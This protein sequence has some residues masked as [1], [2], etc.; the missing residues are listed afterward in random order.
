MTMPRRRFP[1]ILAVAL[2]LAFAV[3]ISAHAQEPDPLI[4]KAQAFL[5]ALTS[6]DFQGAAK[7][8]DAKMLELSGPDKL[9]AFWTQVPAQIGAFKKFTGAVRRE[10]LGTYDIVLVTM[11]FGKNVLDAR[12]VFDPDGKI[13]GFQFL[14]S[15]PPVSYDPPAYA[16][17]AKFEETEVTVGSGEWAL[18][19]TLA[20]PK[21]PGPFPGLVLVHGSGPNDRDE[22]VG[23]NKPFKDLAWGLATRGIAVL[24]YEKR[25]RMHGPLMV[26]NP[27]LAK[28]LTVKEETVDDAALAVALLRSTPRVDPKRVFVLGHSLGGFLMPRIAAAVKPPAAGYIVMAGLARPIPETMVR[29]VTYLSGLDGSISPEEQKEIDKLKVQVARINAYTEADADSN[30]RLLNASPRYFLDLRGYAPAEAAKGVDRSMLILQGARDYQ[31][32]TDDFDLWKAS[33]SGRPDVTFKLY[34]GL[35]HLFFAGKGIP[36]PL[37]Y[38]GMHGSVDEAVVGDISSFISRTLK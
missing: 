29:Q 9:A 32:T 5:K 21:G 37:E 7:D 35:N 15:L 28:T 22:S 17:P 18:P 19:G 16:D 30:E 34:P 24:R 10:K 27:A 2:S 33:L 38:T 11:D 6:G 25:T 4:T 36:N 13:G 1:A 23:P 31:V 20:V 26:A 12:V 14:P 8:F 3:T